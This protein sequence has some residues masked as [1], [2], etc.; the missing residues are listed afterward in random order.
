MLWGAGVAALGACLSVSRL[1]LGFA[2][3]TDVRFWPIAALF[4]QQKSARSGPAYVTRPLSL[5]FRSVTFFVFMYFQI[6]M[7]GFVFF[8]N[9]TALIL[10]AGGFSDRFGAGVN[11]HVFNSFDC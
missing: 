7:F 6:R 1:L 8:S 10:F 9:T 3:F 4:E 11:T 5:L 2:P